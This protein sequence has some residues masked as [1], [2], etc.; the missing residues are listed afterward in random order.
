MAKIKVVFIFRN[1]TQV[2]IKQV[3]MLI[4]IFLARIAENY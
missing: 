2:I 1:I 3:L 4:Q